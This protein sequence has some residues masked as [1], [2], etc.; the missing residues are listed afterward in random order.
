MVCVMVKNLSQCLKEASDNSGYISVKDVGHGNVNPNLRSSAANLNSVQK[1]IDVH[2][3]FNQKAPLESYLEISQLKGF[4][5]Y[6]EDL[7][8][9]ED[10]PAGNIQ[11]RATI[12][13]DP[14]MIADFSKEVRTLDGFIG[15]QLSNFL[16]PV[17]HKMYE[18]YCTPGLPTAHDYF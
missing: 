10:G 16:D 14:K 15:L 7:P 18:R 12:W 3:Y 11:F 1:E 5:E 4:R 13:I 2:V 8:V 9:V 17:E 6:S